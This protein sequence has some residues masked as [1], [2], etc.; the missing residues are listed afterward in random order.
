MVPSNAPEHLQPVDPWQRDVE[1]DDVG[2]ILAN[3][4]ERVAAIRGRR[5]GAPLSLEVV[6]QDVADLA[7]VVDDEDPGL[8]D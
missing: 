5:H 3:A 4:L 7:L 1:K 6:G 2:R 8:E